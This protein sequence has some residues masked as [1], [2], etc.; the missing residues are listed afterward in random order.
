MLAMAYLRL[1]DRNNARLILNEI[2]DKYKDNE[3]LTPEVRKC[4]RVLYIIKD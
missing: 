4:E 2:I 3:D 1:H